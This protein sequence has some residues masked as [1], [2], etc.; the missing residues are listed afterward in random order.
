MGQRVDFQTLLETVLG[1][2]NV[3]FQP[4]SNISMQYPC[5]VYKRVKPVTRH[6]NNLL[7]FNKQ[8]YMVTYID[9]NPDSEVANAL[10]QLPLSGFSR[11]F[12]SDNLNHDV[13]D[14]YF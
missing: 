9:R 3:Y 11:Q 14:I 12:T 10:S 7:Y 8:C 1:S 4:P 5:I 2:K 13:Y 6:A